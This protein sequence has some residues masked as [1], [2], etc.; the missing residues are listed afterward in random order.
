VEK[1]STSGRNKTPAIILS[2]NEIRLI[3]KWYSELQ[4][5]MGQED[6]DLAESLEELLPSNK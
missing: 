3:L 1:E 2:E 4:S 5:D 6:L